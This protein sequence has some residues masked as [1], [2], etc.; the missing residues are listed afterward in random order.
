MG[1]AQRVLRRFERPLVVDRRSDGQR[2]LASLVRCN[3]S[4][5]LMI[6]AVV[7]QRLNAFDKEFQKRGSLP[8]RMV[9]Q[10][11]NLSAPLMS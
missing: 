1:E 6:F 8:C 11:S 4:G 10:G 5:E 7:I 2:R 3:L 9:T